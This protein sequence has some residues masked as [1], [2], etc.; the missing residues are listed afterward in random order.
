[1]MSVLYISSYPIVLR[2]PIIFVFF[3]LMIRRPPRSTLFPYTTLFR[4]QRKGSARPRLVRLF[5]AEGQPADRGRRAARARHPRTERRLGGAP[6]P[7]DVL[8]EAGRQAAAAAPDAR[9]SAARLQGS[10]RARLGPD[11]RRPAVAGSNDA[12]LVTWT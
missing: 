7:R 3:F 5:R 11:R 6:H 12:S 8:R 10:V 9:A 1:H 4:S 2:I